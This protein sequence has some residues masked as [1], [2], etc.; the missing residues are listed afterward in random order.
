MEG[1]YTIRVRK[2]MSN[3]LLHRRQMVVDVYHG[4]A[5]SSGASVSSVSKEDLKERL[6]KM[7]KCRADQVM[8][9]GFKTVFG[10]G[11]SSGFALIYD[12]KDFLARIEPKYRLRRNKLAE[13]RD[14]KNRRS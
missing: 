12:H 1:N 6:A 4:Q 2:F 7:Y 8:L 10:G 14:N 5:L 11:R 13:P 3:K 9:F